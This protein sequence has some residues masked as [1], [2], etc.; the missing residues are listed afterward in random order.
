MAPSVYK[1]AFL[2]I[3]DSNN[4]FFD[5]LCE[6]NPPVEIALSAGTR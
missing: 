5:H 2:G 6:L 3:R 1:M 4:C